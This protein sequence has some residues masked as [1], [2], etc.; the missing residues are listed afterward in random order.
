M[1]KVCN[2]VVCIFS[3]VVVTTELDS[4]L[5]CNQTLIVLVPAT[6]TEDLLGSVF[7]R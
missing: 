7:A 1:H 6:Q 4:C 3:N 2:R 5:A